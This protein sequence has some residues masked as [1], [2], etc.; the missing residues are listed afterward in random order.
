M[1]DS[2]ILQHA[3]VRFNAK[4]ATVQH[5]F[6]STGWEVEC[7]PGMDGSQQFPQDERNWMD[8]WV[9]RQQ[10]LSGKFKVVGVHTIEVKI[11]SFSLQYM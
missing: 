2:D 8:G 10:C 7:G 5:A 4:A 9:L 11:H 1:N 3:F 6:L